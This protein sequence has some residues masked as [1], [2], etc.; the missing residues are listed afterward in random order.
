MELAAQHLERSPLAWILTEGNTD[1]L[2]GRVT[3]A[4]PPEMANLFPKEPGSTSIPAVSVITKLI[5]YIF[6]DFRSLFQKFIQVMLSIN[7]LQ[8]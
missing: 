5:L 3:E 7:Q 2:E 6:K 8:L 4:N 1:S